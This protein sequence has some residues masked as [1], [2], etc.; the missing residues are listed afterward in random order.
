MATV[1]DATLDR[2]IPSG[3]LGRWL[4][5]GSF[6]VLD[7]GIYAG[8][9]FVASILLARWLSPHQF[10]AFAIAFALLSLLVTLHA[11]VLTEPLGVYGA[12]AYSDRFRSYLRHVFVAQAALTVGAAGLVAVAGLALDATGS[13]AAGHAL[14]GLAAAL[15]F[16][17]L[18]WLTRRVFYA[19]FSPHWATL[20][21]VLY[22]GLSLPAII[23]LH[24]EGHLTPASAFL[25]AGACCLVASVVLFLL[26]P[27]RLPADTGAPVTR[28][29]VASEHGRYARWAVAAALTI[30]LSANV[31]Y[32]VLSATGF[33]AVGAM[34]ALDTILMPYWQY[35]AATA[36]FLLPSLSQRLAAGPAAAAELRRR[37]WRIY[38]AQAVVVTLVLVLAGPWIMSL[39]YGSKYDQYEHLLPILALIVVPETLAALMLTIWR[40][41]VRTRLVFLF[42]VT[43]SAAFLAA[44]ALGSIWSVSGVVVARVVVSF[45]VVAVFLFVAARKKA[46]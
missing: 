20:G 31:Q 39:L 38:L 9:T 29:A 5:M 10:G 8:S 19:R 21:S 11:A 36:G 18:F 25:A 35:L 17:L 15:P 22:A 3:G 6:S 16:I 23:V 14:Y 1:T 43:F 2:Q 44:A 34:R 26:M 7:Q 40:S 33:A 24:A 46:A 28:R 27:R 13:T 32:F 4:R 12:G 42:S 41:Q 37:L 45:V 30:W